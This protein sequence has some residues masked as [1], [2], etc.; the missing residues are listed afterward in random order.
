MLVVAALLLASCA[1]DATAPPSVLAKQDKVAPQASGSPV[2]V[3]SGLDSPRGL[4]FGPEG[5]LY[6]VEAGTAQINGPCVTIARGSNCYSGTGA[7]TRL[8]RGT[9]ERIASGLPSFYNPGVLDIGGPQ[10]IDFQGRGNGFVSSGWGANPALR[11]GLGS[12]GD[13]FASMLRVTPNG[14][15][16][17]VADPGTHELLTN[18]AGG[19]IDSNPYGVLA[20]AGVQYLTDAG[21]NSLLKVIDGVVSTVATFPSTPIAPGSFP[22]P[23]TSSEAVP[24]EVTRGPDG[25]LYVSTLSGVP[26]LPGAA[27]IYRV[28]EGQAPT[29]F[30]AGLTQV[31][32]HAWGANGAL[33]VLQYASGPF[34]S[35]PGSIVRIAAGG[36]RTTVFVGLTNPTGIIVG[37][38]GALYVSN[39]GNVAS[40]GEVLRITP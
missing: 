23:F 28:V 31:T 26:F 39:R 8:W 7:I 32:D 11:A 25:A 12:L 40:V 17:K 14:G 13:N 34:F 5:A 18:P 3:M 24:T 21:G 38:D 22:G 10:D 35:G 16:T 19:P 6:V 9:Q 27:R 4:A 30:A 15:W 29:V 2:A 33:Y 37:P 20:E 36:A 1:D